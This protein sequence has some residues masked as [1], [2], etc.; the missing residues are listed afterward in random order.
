MA[1]LFI[2]L[3]EDYVLTDQS[4]VKQNEVGIV[5]AD[6]WRNNDILDCRVFLI[7]EW[8][9]VL[10]E[11]PKLNLFDPSKTGDGFINKVCNVCHKLLPTDKFAKNQ[12]GINNRSVRRPSCQDCRKH[13]EGKDLSAKDKKLWGAKKRDLG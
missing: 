12:N 9:E 10:L 4:I 3:Q 8:R 13:I 1:N 2:Y 11:K 6:D 5:N 7:P